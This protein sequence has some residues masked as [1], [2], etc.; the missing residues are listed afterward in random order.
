MNAMVYRAIISEVLEGI[1]TRGNRVSVIVLSVES[2][3]IPII[4]TPDQTVSIQSGLNESGDLAIS[5]ENEHP[6][7]NKHDLIGKIH[8]ALDAE[9]TEVRIDSLTD[10]TYHAKIFAIQ[11]WND[12]SRDITV[13]S[14]ATDAIATGVCVGCPITINEQVVNEAGLT[15][16]EFNKHFSEP[17]NTR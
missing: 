6:S 4:T 16:N 9:I 12:H 1:D 5:S 2:L 10:N 8:N 17:N 7:G 3:F 15:E 14:R 13:D 11:N